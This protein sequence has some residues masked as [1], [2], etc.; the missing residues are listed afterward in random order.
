M[1]TV[2]EGWDAAIARRVAIK[3]VPLAQNAQPDEWQNLTRFRREAQTAG[4]LQHPAVVGIFDYGENAE[5]AFIVMEFVD[6]GTLKAA[7]EK[8]KRFSIEA[9]DRLMQDI[10]AGLQYSH[11]QG[12]IHR[13]IKP[14]NI[15]LTHDGHAK[16]AD[17]GIARIEHSDITQIG[18]VMGTPA[19]MSPEQFRGETT[20]A[21]T[22]IYSSGVIL[23]QLL[24][25]ERPFDG[26]LATIMHKALGTDPPKPSDISGT[27]PHSVDAVVARAMAKRPDHRYPDA[28]AFGQALHAALTAKPAAGPKPAVRMA[29]GPVPLGRAAIPRDGG[30]LFSRTQMATAAAAIMLVLAGGTVAYRMS[31]PHP[32]PKLEERPQASMAPSP[33]KPVTATVPAAGPSS[34]QA[35]QT[36]GTAQPPVPSPPV[37]PE[38]LPLPVSIDA[39]PPPPPASFQAPLSPPVPPLLPDT[40]ARVPLPTLQ[41]PPAPQYTLPLGMPNASAGAQK[42]QQAPRRETRSPPRSV[43]R[44]TAGPD[45]DASPPQLPVLPNHQGAGPVDRRVREAPALAEAGKPGTPDAVAAGPLIAPQVESPPPRIFGTFGIVNGKRVFVPTSDPTR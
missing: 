7:L 13:D 24:T 4:R 16:I 38:A 26:G 41:A 45:D 39:T 6:G 42:A 20:T 27:A 1:S 22:D 35:S 43:V 2:Y 9:I 25:G 8:G 21:S 12:V 10:L 40:Q 29:K 30:A 44:Q 36:G 23:Y 37:K 11:D 14:A 15:M 33:S 3:A 17:F 18:M 34:N 31:I 32:A 28:K 19:Y 5:F